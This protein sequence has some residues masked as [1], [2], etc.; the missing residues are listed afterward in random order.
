VAKERIK[1]FQS[2]S[3]FFRPCN[4]Q[5][6]YF[7][8]LDFFVS[9]PVGFFQALQRKSHFITDPVEQLG[10]N[11]CRVFSGLATS[12]TRPRRTTSKCFNPCRVFSGLATSFP[13]CLMRWSLPEFQ[14]LS[15]FFRP[16]NRGNLDRVYGFSTVSIPVGFF[17]ALQ[18][19]S[20]T[21]DGLPTGCF[22][23]CRVFSGLATKR[24]HRSLRTV[25]LCFNP[26]RVFSG[27]ATVVQ[28]H[29]P[30]TS[31]VF[32][33]LSGFFRPCNRP[34]RKLFYC[35]NNV[36]I[37]VGFFQALQQKLSVS[38]PAREL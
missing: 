2:L 22:N 37:P 35:A 7:R 36:S 19:V 25:P 15:G 34:P 24:P 13:A 14:S 1:K 31:Q 5:F 18:P 4:I 8:S 16:C 38:A 6:G 27:L 29:D 30:K 21:V 32:Q 9:I 3:G 23:P 33:S 26:C 12:L 28:H 20:S 17:Q 11:P 10:F